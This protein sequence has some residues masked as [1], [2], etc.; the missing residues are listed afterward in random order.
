MNNLIDRNNKPWCECDSAIGRG[1]H[2]GCGKL[3]EYCYRLDHPV[4]YW[5]YA[6]VLKKG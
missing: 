5:F 3:D 2:A 6:K 4:K 1:F